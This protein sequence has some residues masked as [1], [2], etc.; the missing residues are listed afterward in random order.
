V[1]TRV[2]LSTI[3]PRCNGPKD[4]GASICARCLALANADSDQAQSFGQWTLLSSRTG[5]DWR[6]HFSIVAREAQLGGEPWPHISSSNRHGSKGGN[7]QIL[8]VNPVKQ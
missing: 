1:T 8:K 3:C 6:F 4:L 2:M 7:G 5:W